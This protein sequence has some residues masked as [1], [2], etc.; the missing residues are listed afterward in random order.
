MKK[1]LFFAKR[2]S[3]KSREV[4]TIGINHRVGN[5]DFELRWRDD[6]RFLGG[7]FLAPVES[8]APEHHRSAATHSASL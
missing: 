5:R 2:G 1:S 8:I 6:C 4:A 3:E 7:L